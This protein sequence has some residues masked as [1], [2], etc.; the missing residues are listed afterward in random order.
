VEAARS[1]AGEDG[2]VHLTNLVLT[3]VGRA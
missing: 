2:T 3:A 1:H